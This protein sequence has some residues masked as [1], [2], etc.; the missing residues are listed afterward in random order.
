[1]TLKCLSKII[2]FL[3]SLFIAVAG[4]P[5]VVILKIKIKIKVLGC[6]QDYLS[7]I[8]FNISLPVNL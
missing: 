7:S 2:S 5:L 1:M 3:L 6:R 8:I 4:K